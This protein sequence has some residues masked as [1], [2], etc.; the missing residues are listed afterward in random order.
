MALSFQGQTV[1]VTGAGGS[2]GRAY[3]LAYGERGANVVVNDLNGEAAARV[4]QEIISAGGKAV[5]D[6]HSVTDGAA[7]VR[8]ALD[9]FGG[10]H[11]L[12]NN[13]GTIVLESFTDKQWDGLVN[14]HLKGTIS[15]TQAA[16]PVFH[17]QKFGRIVNTI[18]AAGLYGFPP[19]CVY[20]AVKAGI[21]S[22]TKTSAKEGEDFNVRVNAVAPASD[23]QMSRDFVPEHILRTMPP[24]VLPPLVLALTHETMGPKVTGS[25]FE[26]FSGW[27]AE[28]RPTI[29]RGIQ[30]HAG[31]PLS[32]SAVLKSWAAIA[33]D[34][35]AHASF[36]DQ[37][38]R[39]DGETVIVTKAATSLGRAYAKAF[40][41]LG[42]NVV[43]AD[44]DDERVNRLTQEIVQDGGKAVGV[45]TSGTT[46]AELVQTALEA[47]GAVHV[48][49]TNADT[50]FKGELQEINE[51]QW[52]ELIEEHGK[53][54]FKESRACWPIFKRQNYGRVILTSST[55]SIHGSAGNAPFAAG[56]GMLLGLA[57]ALSNG[58]ESDGIF[59]NV[60]APSD[61]GLSDTQTSSAA[62]AAFMASK[63]NTGVNGAVVEV[64]GDL[65]GQFRWERSGGHAFD[66]NESFTP[67]AV[68][69]QWSRVTGFGE[70]RTIIRAPVQALRIFIDDE[71]VSNPWRIGETMAK[72]SSL[73]FPRISMVDL[74]PR[75]V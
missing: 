51:T 42:G 70:D 56:K 62:V 49:V 75:W 26:N 59:V 50:A 15:C 24:H 43:V 10:L 72:V 7:V 2:I 48:L 33:P 1:I 36:E 40:G 73:I 21:I 54:A 55:S 67:E 22:F 37:D 52:D 39:L 19:D 20:S 64:D 23:S 46:T 3:A 58:S 18:S 4:V 53:D 65:V 16:W 74:L 32:P 13:A 66:S 71:R 45:V 47:Y 60:V 38:L 41:Q 29:T 69:S 30:F 5:A 6:S 61:N 44:S 11:I 9:T 12:I 25:L 68:I 63:A 27:M 34:F 8:T 14:V 17:E 35:A 31:E 57:R 28:V